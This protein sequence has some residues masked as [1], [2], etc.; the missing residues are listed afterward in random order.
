M[1]G[2][3][4]NLTPEMLLWEVGA[5]LARHGIA[6]S[7]ANPT[8]AVGAAERLLRALGLSTPAPEPT[9]IPATA[10]QPL[11]DPTALRQFEQATGHRPLPTE[12]P[13]ARHRA[14]GA[15]RLVPEGGA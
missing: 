7:T 1:S 12:S 4:P 9:A 3:A 14:N 2:D 5:I 15:L 13:L 11:I 8:A 6:Y 10:S